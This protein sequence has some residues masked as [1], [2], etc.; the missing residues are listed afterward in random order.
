MSYILHIESATKN[1]SVS[2]SQNGKHVTV[3]E[4]VTEQYSHSENLMPFIDKLLSKAQI[5]RKEL[6]AV[7]VSK[8]PG[9][10][11]GLRI[12]VSLA[13]GLCSALSIPLISVETPKVLAQTLLLGQNLG[14]DAVICSALDARRME[15]Y[16]AFYDAQLN[17]LGDISAKIVEADFLASFQDKKVYV[18][19]DATEKMQAVINHSNIEFIQLFP[20]AKGLEKLS[21]EKFQNQ[22]FE[23]VAYFEP[24]YL[25]EFMVG[26]H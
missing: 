4:E 6:A 14:E 5:D 9:S 16:H 8:G 22:N 26:G 19:G 24:F 20:S 2:L 25:K 21:F 23:N 3:I 15:V 1:C 17:P 10:Y 13:K 7:A 12:G 11:T 18:I